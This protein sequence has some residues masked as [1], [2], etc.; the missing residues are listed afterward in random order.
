MKRLFPFT[1]F[2][3]LAACTSFLTTPTAFPFPSLPPRTV[4]PTA[5]IPTPLPT[6]TATPVQSA[7]L[8][9]ENIQ[10]LRAWVR[11]SNPY[12]RSLAFSP[13]SMQ[14][15][16][17]SGNKGDGF[18]LGTVWKPADGGMAA[19]LEG[20]TGTV[21]DLAYSPNGRRIASVADSIFLERGRIH[22]A[23]T[24]IGQLVVSGSGQAYS[25]AYSPDGSQLAIGGIDGSLNGR[26]WIYDALTAGLIRELKASSQN[27]LDLVYTA[28]G[29]QLISTGT[30]GLIRRWDAR[31]GRL[32]GTLREKIQANRI[33]LSPDGTLLA[34]I[35]CEKSGPSGCDKG[36]VSV[37]RLPEGT[38]VMSFTDLAEA[39]AFS[40][41]GGML[42]V[43]SGA[44]TPRI[45]I[46]DTAAWATLWDAGVEAANLAFSLDGRWLATANMSDITIWSVP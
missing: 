17:A 19:S 39:V 31:D 21:W 7:V 43:G 9:A 37:W 23:Q 27:V 2:I 26:I 45:R 44:S 14:L 36:G 16:A 42:A 12:T 18:F 15:A 11:I 5:I 32:L 46:R 1:L 28:D 40:A 30:D 13:D 29:S 35:Y 6:S 8:S 34:S 33:A 10:N 20:F 24:G 38:R 4:T 25:V 22:D 41:D 3:L